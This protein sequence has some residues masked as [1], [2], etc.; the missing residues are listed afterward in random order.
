LFFFAILVLH[1]QQKQVKML[2]EGDNVLRTE[3]YAL[4]VS[5]L[6][7]ANYNYDPTEGLQL[8]DHL[9]I[10]QWVDESDVRVS[11]VSYSSMTSKELLDLDIESL[12]SELT[13]QLKTSVAR[14]NM[15]AFFILSPIIKEAN[16][17]IKKVTSFSVTYS[18]GR[19]PSNR[20]QRV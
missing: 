3:S 13:Y 15:H 1:S 8:I 17:S 12:P 9:Q 5:A 4:K 10:K 18:N 19:L 6:N 14:D 11:H 2:W 16:G 20:N 7:D